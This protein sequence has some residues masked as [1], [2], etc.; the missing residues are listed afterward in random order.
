MNRRQHRQL[1][2]D[3]VCPPAGGLDRIGLEQHADVMTDNLAV[4]HP[5]FVHNNQ[6]P[7]RRFIR[8]GSRRVSEQIDVVGEGLVGGG[9][10]LVL[11]RDDTR[12][13][14]REQHL[15]AALLDDDVLVITS[16][17]DRLRQAGLVTHLKTVALTLEPVPGRR[18]VPAIG[19]VEPHLQI[20]RLPIRHREQRPT[21]VEHAPIGRVGRAIDPSGPIFFQ[22]VSQVDDATDPDRR[23]AILELTRAARAHMEPP[24]R[25]RKD[26]LDHRYP[27][28]LGGDCNRVR[29]RCFVTT[30]TEQRQS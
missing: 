1:V 4:S 17:Q 23:R 15:E 13:T 9:A 5:G 28:R 16:E 2:D 18:G 7:R 14:E 20:V 22:I 6:N 11:S 3:L 27:R 10:K 12:A 8:R 29:G 21:G 26:D 19:E 25:R 30:L 24:N